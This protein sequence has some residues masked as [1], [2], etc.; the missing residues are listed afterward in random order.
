M[1]KLKLSFKWVLWR[2]SIVLWNSV[3]N[4]GNP[5]W[6]LLSWLLRLIVRMLW[7][8]LHVMN[9][10]L[11]SKMDGSVD[12]DEHSRR[13]S[14][15]TDDPYTEKVN[16]LVC[17]NW[18]LPVRELAEECGISNQSRCHTPLQF[19]NPDWKIE[20][21]SSRCQIHVSPDDSTPE[22]AS[23]SS[24]SGTVWSS[25]TGLNLLARNQ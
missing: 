15:S 8:V 7:N 24:L 23:N 12:D 20:D 22:T 16:D 6:K 5:S 19:F 3:W 21:A 13:L 1:A 4:L 17:A 18:R 9:C 11:G 10:L 14:M 2:S 25:W